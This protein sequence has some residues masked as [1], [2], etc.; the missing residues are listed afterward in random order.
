MANSFGIPVFKTE[1]IDDMPFEQ[2][3]VLV[4]LINE[5]NR[6]SELESSSDDAYHGLQ[7]NKKTTYRII[8][9][10]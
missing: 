3:R 10:E 5:R 4:A 9:E 7:S 2:Y 1:S 8:N 6:Q